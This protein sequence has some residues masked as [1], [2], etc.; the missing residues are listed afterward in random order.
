MVASPVLEP[1]ISKRF[2]GSLDS[3][4][5]ESLAREAC[6][7]IEVVERFYEEALADLQSN[8][9]V[10]NFIEVIAGRRVRER[11]KRSR[12]ESSTSVISGRLPPA[13][14]L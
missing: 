2:R 1:M 9:K 10:K 5:V 7:P 3:S 8:S 13:F 11:I 4:T 6:V 12:S 14:G